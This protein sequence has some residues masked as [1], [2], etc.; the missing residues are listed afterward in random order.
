[1]TFLLPFEGGQVLYRVRSPA[2][3]FERVVAEGDLS[4][5]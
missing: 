4:A 2:E 5:P 3:S 1:V